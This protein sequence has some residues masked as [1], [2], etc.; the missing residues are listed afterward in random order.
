MTKLQPGDIKVR[1]EKAAAFI[2]NSLKNSLQ[3][4]L[5]TVELEHFDHFSLL[6]HLKESIACIQRFIGEKRSKVNDGKPSYNQPSVKELCQ[7][8]VIILKS[9]QKLHFLEQD[10]QHNSYQF[11][12]PKDV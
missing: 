4:S 11:K 2:N 5:K 8:D 1:K 3:N 12:G 7:A 10:L 9:L 6:H